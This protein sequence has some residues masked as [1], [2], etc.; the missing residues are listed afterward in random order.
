MVRRFTPGGAVAGPLFFALL[1]GGCSDP[2]SVR[3]VDYGTGTPLSGATVQRMALKCPYFIVG[4]MVPVETR[5]TGANGVSKLQDRDGVLFIA[6]SGY[7]SAKARTEAQ[8]IELHRAVA[9]GGAP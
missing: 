2:F 5:T 9:E 7:T 6:A 3:V 4:G 8:T 1:A